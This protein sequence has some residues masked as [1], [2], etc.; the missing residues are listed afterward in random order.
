MFTE[1]F[2]VECFDKFQSVIKLQRSLGDRIE[3]A[4]MSPDQIKELIKEVVEDNKSN[5]FM[6]TCF[7]WYFMS[8]TCEDGYDVETG[9]W[10]VPKDIFNMR[11]F[12]DAFERL[13]SV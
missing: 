7:V 10:S 2:K 3:F 1:E 8:W 13:S 6:V 5:P 11:L 12:Y 4:L 9:M